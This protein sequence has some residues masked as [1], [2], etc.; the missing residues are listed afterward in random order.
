[1]KEKNMVSFL[2]EQNIICNQTK[3]D[4]VGHEQTIICGQLFVGHVVGFLPMND[5]NYYS[6]SGGNYFLTRIPCSIYF[7]QTG[8]CPV[9][10]EWL[11]HLSG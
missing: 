3:L 11:K 4:D 2:H 6:S 1:M 8:E 5:K 9:E 10:C 7:S